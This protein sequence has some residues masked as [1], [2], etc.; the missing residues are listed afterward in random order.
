MKRFALAAAVLA[1]TA[2]SLAKADTPA[3]PAAPTAAPATQPAGPALA[4]TVKNIDGQTTDLSQYQGKVVLIVNVASK[5]GNTPQYAVLEKM[6]A[7][8]KDKGFTI[9]GFPAND[10]HAQEPGTDAEI[11]EF[12]T[13]T[14]H[15]DFPMFS[16]IVVKGEGQAPLYAYLT[17]Q[18]TKP[19]KKGDITWNFEKFLVNKKGEVVARFTPKTQPNDPKVTAAIEAELA[20]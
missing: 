6:Y 11:K 4:F 8:Y 9:L 19:A 15:V 10:F 5:C 3:A 14:Y 20:K 2:F 1:L 18:D 7:D 16:K 12:C 13:A 17:A